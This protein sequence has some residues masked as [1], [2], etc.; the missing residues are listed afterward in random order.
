M[1]EIA[2]KYFSTGEFAKLCKVHKK[3]LFHYDDIDLFK[4]EK[5][6]ENGYRYYSEYQLESFN[7][8]YTLKG[9]GMPLKEIKDFMN[10]RN[11]QN[12]VELFEYETLE[13]EKEITKLRKMQEIISN[14][15]KV[16]KEGQVNYNNIFIE[17]QEDDYIIL[18]NSID[19]LKS[20]YDID[21][22]LSHLD[23]C[24]N[25]N[26]YIGYPIGSIKTK[27]VLE[28]GNIFEY[29]YYYTK[30]NKNSKN[31]NIVI[32]PKGTYVVGYLKGYYDKAPS[33]YSKL[34]EFI[35]SNNLIIIGCSY[36]D[37]LIDE[38]AVKNMDEFILKVSIEVKKA[39]II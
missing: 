33:L 13:I 22:Y 34:L 4:P 20:P 29:S 7:V 2:T 30:V 14:K 10:R 27:D 12:T 18:S 5:V 38:V 8:I 17:E 26:L 24:Y 16:I 1:K 11:P 39:S 21:T 37:V 25:N 31:K 6:M 19:I 15:I 3:T 9:L 35:K 23:Y 36:E 32:K 28:N